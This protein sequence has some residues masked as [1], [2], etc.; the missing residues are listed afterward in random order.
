MATDKVFC[1]RHGL[2]SSATSQSGS[3]NPS[4][5]STNPATNPVVC[6]SGRPNNTCIVRPAWIAASLYRY[7]VGHNVVG[8]DVC[9]GAWLS[10]P[11][12]DQTGSQGRRAASGNDDK[13]TGSGSSMSS[14]ANRSFQTATMMESRRESLS[15]NI[16]ETKPFKA[17]ILFVAGNAVAGRSTRI[18]RPL[19]IGV[20][21][22]L[23]DLP[24]GS[25]VFNRAFI[26]PVTS[27]IRYRPGDFVHQQHPG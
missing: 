14:G 22:R 26:G 21:L 20:Q 24:G 16:C 6:R 4:R 7:N 8:G 19:H 10:N 17:L 9:P 27:K 11:T 25:N 3:T 2:L 5:L 15:Y 1:R 23:I 12:C 13:Q 18:K